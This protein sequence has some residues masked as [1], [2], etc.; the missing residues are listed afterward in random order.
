MNNIP[1]VESGEFQKLVGY[2][3]TE[4]DIDHAAISLEMAEHHSNRYGHA[5]GGVL[6]TIL[7]AACT[8]AGAMCPDT[9]KIRKSATVSMTT[10]FIHPAKNTRLR[11]IARKTGG[12]RRIFFATADAY[13]SN[14]NL[15]ATCV[16]TCRYS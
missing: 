5:H 11:V 10:N 12:G 13:D 1:D 8:R 7:D 15:I 2:K 6:M 16:A 4:W 3:I 9:G 14:N